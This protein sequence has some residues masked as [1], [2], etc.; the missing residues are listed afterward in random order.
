MLWVGEAFASARFQV[1]DPGEPVCLDEIGVQCLHP[2]ARVHLPPVWPAA[3]QSRGLPV[4]FETAKIPR[5]I[6]PHIADAGADKLAQLA[7]DF[8]EAVS[9]ERLRRG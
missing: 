5:P 9:Q 7:L 8:V 4:L 2:L 3:V 6:P 1:V